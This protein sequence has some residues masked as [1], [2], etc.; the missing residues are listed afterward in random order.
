M[1]KDFKR[2]LDD[3]RSHAKLLLDACNRFSAEHN[4]DEVKNIGVR[5]R[6]LVGSQKGDVM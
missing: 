6:V 3:F 2:R 1:Q 5:L 4:L